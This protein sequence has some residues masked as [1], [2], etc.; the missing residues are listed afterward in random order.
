MPRCQMSPGLICVTHFSL[1]VVASMAM[2]AQAWSVS[3]RGLSFVGLRGELLV[4]VPKKISFV[5]G[6]YDGVAQT[7]LVDG[8]QRKTCSPQASLMTIGGSSGSGLGPTSY[9]HAILPL[10]G[11]TATTNPRP[12]QAR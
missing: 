11:S 1:P 9:F 2:I 4:S 5:A 10:C 3:R 6:S 7:V 8:P 12:E